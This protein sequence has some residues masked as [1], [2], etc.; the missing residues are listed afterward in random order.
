MTD[1]IESTVNLAR[2]DP[3]IGSRVAAWFTLLPQWEAE[4]INNLYN[5]DHLTAFLDQF[6]FAL[7]HNQYHRGG[8]PNVTSI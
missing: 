3:H 7:W 5:K 1:L 2:T 8:I 6:R 4:D